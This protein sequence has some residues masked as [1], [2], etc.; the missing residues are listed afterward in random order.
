M[1]LLIPRKPLLAGWMLA[2]FIFAAAHPPVL[3]QSRMTTAKLGRLLKTLATDLRGTNGRW[4]FR[5]QGVPMIALTDERVDRIR[6][7]SFI[8]EG[9]DLDRERLL[10]LLRAN[11][12]RT[13]DARYALFRG[14]LVAAF[15]HPL[16]SLKADPFES[17][18]KQVGNLVRNYGGTY[19][20]GA[21]RFRTGGR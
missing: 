10:L 3:A 16:R 1:T 6:V 15:M 17:A 4:D 14:F 21:L 5:F 20:S 13:L 19:S 2:G 8:V 18:L 11:F 12:D 9:A 7:I